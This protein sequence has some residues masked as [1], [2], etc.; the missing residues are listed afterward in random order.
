M[1]IKKKILWVDDEID[2]LKSHI[3]FLTE[4]GYEVETASNGEDALALLKEKNFDAIFID[5][6]MPGLGGLELLAKLKEINYTAPVIM[7]TKNEAES[8]MNE[9]IGSK[10]FDYLIKPIKPSQVLLALKKLFD[11]KIISSQQIVKSYISDFNELSMLINSNPNWNE[12]INI[13]LKLTSWEFELTEHSDQGLKE[14][15]AEL[16][17]SANLTF[18]KTIEREYPEWIHTQKL[19]SRPIL[20]TDILDQKILNSLRSGEKNILFLV[21]DCLR[22][23][24]WMIMENFLKD[25]YYIKKDYYYTILPTATAYARNSLFAGLFP[26]ELE[27]YYP[28]IYDVNIQNENTRNQYEKELLNLFLQRKRVKLK[29]NIKYVKIIDQDFGRNFEQNAL[30]IQNNHLSVIVYNFLDMIAHGRSDSALLKE[31]APDESAYRA[32]TKTWFAHSN[33]YS[34]FKI[35]SQL[36]NTIIYVTTDHGSIRTLRGAKV[37]GDRYA[38][39]SLRFKYGRN[40]KADER[41]AIFVKNPSNYKLPQI[42]AAINYI[43][44]R[45]DYFFLFPNDYNVYLNLYNDTFQHGGVSLEEMIVPFI[46][47]QSKLS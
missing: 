41:N 6:M 27:K 35:F 15:L 11:A 46:E 19:Q 43:F 24:Q 10:I 2:L 26:N 25:F 38:A 29:N 8:L 34:L 14:S 3:L 28:D 32:L 13:Y 31:I 18:S 23:D 22:L 9:A 37:L 45:E 30:S 16:K 36:K 7:I 47:L 39:T 17:R 44:A 33:L 20:T 42:S 5:E 4:K 40:L 12:W 21:I 1:T